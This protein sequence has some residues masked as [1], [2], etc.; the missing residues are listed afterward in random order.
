MNKDETSQ[1]PERRFQIFRTADGP[2]LME[3]GVMQI[4]PLS[5]E[6]T[7]GIKQLIDNGY[8]AGDVVRVVFNIP[9]FSLTH[10]WLKSQYPLIRHTHD[11]D[12][13]YFIIAGSIA[14][15][16]QTLG[17]REGF[18]VPANAPYVYRPGLEGVELLEF[19]HSTKF[20]ISILPASAAFW[21]K[22]LETCRRQKDE[23]ATAKPPAP[24]PLNSCD[25]TQTA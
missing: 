23:W 6:T 25:S 1:V 15:G 13:L 19:R 5:P 11:A 21:E 2:L 24:T 14:L 8:L 17:P 20:D 9:G 16:S 7:E 12:C 4:Q 18:F 10:V 22:A 3:S